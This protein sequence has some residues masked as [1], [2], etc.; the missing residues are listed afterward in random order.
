M[1]FHFVISVFQVV[2]LENHNNI[3]SIRGI[4]T[5]DLLQAQKTGKNIATPSAAD[6]ESSRLS[7]ADNISIEP[8]PVGKDT[9][10]KK[11]HLHE[12]V[13]T[14]QTDSGISSGPA[15][16]NTCDEEGF[17][18]AT[19][20]SSV[21]RKREKKRKRETD[22]EPIMFEELTVSEPEPEPEPVSPPKKKKKKRHSE[23]LMDGQSYLP[24][25]I[26]DTAV[27]SDQPASSAETGDEKGSGLGTK[28]KKSKKKDRYVDG[29]N[30]EGES[31]QFTDILAQNSV[32]VNIDITHSS[33]N[34]TVKEKMKKK[35]QA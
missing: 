17:S 9:P 11:K 14:V 33:S 3:C 21:A 26:S 29:G 8:T 16:L 28:K 24:E 35:K 10:R 34:I 7:T 19:T 23:Q 27:E 13:V 31:G 5:N 18:D 6:K 30:E 1:R 22:V 4:L 12:E 2:R 15:S 20:A 25:S 32:D